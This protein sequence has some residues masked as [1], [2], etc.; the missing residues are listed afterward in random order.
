LNP[1][2]TY[3][4]SFLAFVAGGM[5]HSEALDQFDRKEWNAALVAELS[6]IRL[7]PKTL[8]MEVHDGLPPLLSLDS[9]AGREQADQKDME[10]AIELWGAGWTSEVPDCFRHNSRDFWRQCPVMSWYWRRPSRRQGK[11][12]RKY[13]STNRAWMAM[14]RGE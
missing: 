13:L 9:M 4:D 7:N 3:R 1:I 6:L 11:P 8:N 12:G 10:Q 14:K 5:T 2:D